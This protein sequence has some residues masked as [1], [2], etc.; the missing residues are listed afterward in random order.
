MAA[1]DHVSQFNYTQTAEVE[2]DWKCY[3]AWNRQFPIASPML[4][5]QRACLAHSLQPIRHPNIASPYVDVVTLTSHTAL[6]RTIPGPHAS[7]DV[8]KQL[9]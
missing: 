1:V 4:A 2:Q 5:T 9:R 3:P 8:A 6:P 7:N